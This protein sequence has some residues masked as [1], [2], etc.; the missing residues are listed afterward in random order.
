MSFNVEGQIL[1]FKAENNMTE[2]YVA[3]EIGT[4]AGEV[5]LPSA[6][7]DIVVGI[8]QHTANAGEM[9]DVMVS[10]VSKCV[11]NGAVAKGARVNLAATTGR[12]DDD[13]AGY[14]AV[15]LSLEASSGA[16]EVIP[17]LLSTPGVAV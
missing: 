13:Q 10:G 9:V 5:D 16:G 2:A 8:I 6:A 3:V 4:A 15:G 14:T 7:T 1:S 11:T 12:V 17:V